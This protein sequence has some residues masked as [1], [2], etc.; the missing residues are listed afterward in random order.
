MLRTITP[1]EMKRVENRVMRET[2]LTGDR[3]MQNAAAH[4]AQ[5]V[6][7]RMAGRAGQVV[8]LCGTGNNGGDGLAAMR[9]LAQEDPAFRGECWL[10]PGALSA[11]AQRELS[12]LR[13]AAEDRVAVRRAE[14]GP[15][16]PQEAACAV[17]ALFGTGLSRPLEGAARMACE[18]LNALAEA[19]VPVVA[20]DIPSGL[21]GETGQVMGAAVRAC[22]TVT[23]HRP[24]PGLYLGQGPD[25]AGEITVADIGLSA[26]EAAALDD[27]DGMRVLERG[28]RLLPPRSKTA[29]KGSFGRVVLWAGSRGMAGAAAI[30]ATAALRAGAGLVTV[31]C[32]DD[33]VDVVQTLCPCATCAP[34]STQDEDAAWESL[35]AALERADALGAGCGLGQGPMAVGLMERLLCFLHGRA[36]PCVLDADALNLLARR[37]AWLA[38]GAAI[39]LT[40][41]PGEAARLLG[42]STAEIVADVP[43]AAARIRR[44]YGAAVVLKGARSVLCAQ[45]GLALNPF[46][47]PAMAKGGSGDALTGIMAALLAGRAAGA[48]AMDDLFLMQSACALHGLAGERAAQRC[49]ERGMLATDLCECLGFDFREETPQRSVQPCAALSPLGRTVHVTVEHRRGTRDAQGR[50]YEL[51]CGHVAECLESENR[52]QD[53]CLLGVSGSPEWFEGEVAARVM[54][55]GGEMWVVAPKGTRPTPEEVR[56][57]TAFLGPAEGVEVAR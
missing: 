19:G 32:P 40:P 39:V 10:L 27:A 11:D 34:L 49:G 56:R 7:R 42:M 14:D 5:A 57:A 26:P 28:E 52:W 8:C 47:T 29:H 35:S 51:P 12:R 41:H 9:M 4:V 6:R 46:G 1:S 36:L 18:A 3:L 20:V 48:Y 54:L 30:A 24:K 37:P 2:A 33:V 43:G 44:R 53:A 45:E 38:D 13:E 23:F 31:A 15:A 22:E 50:V 55:A 25:F 17:D 16:L 21:N